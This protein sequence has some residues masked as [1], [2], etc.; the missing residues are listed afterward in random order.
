MPSL[1]PSLRQTKKL[2]AKYLKTTKVPI[3]TVSG[4]YKEDLKGLHHLPENDLLQ[5]I[6]LSRAHYSMAIGVAA[7]AW[8]NKLDPQEAWLVDPTLLE[9]NGVV[10]FLQ[11]Q[12]VKS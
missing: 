2:D 8:K 6:V 5:D 3:I 4:T 7:E 9:K 12:L 10:S 1:T 11:T